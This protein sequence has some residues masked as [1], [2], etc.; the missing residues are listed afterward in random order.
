MYTFDGDTAM[1]ATNLTFTGTTDTN[2]MG[3]STVLIA[4]ATNISGVHITQP[5][6]GIGTVTVADYADTKGILFDAT[7]T[8]S[9]VVEDSAVKYKVNTVKMS[10]VDLKNWDGTVASPT[11][12]VPTGWTAQ[13]GGV[14]V[15]TDNMTKLPTN[16]APG[17]SVDILTGSAGFFADDKIQGA[18]K[19]Q[20]GDAF[21]VKPN[22]DTGM[23]ITGNAVGGIKTESEGA[24]LTYYAEK[25]SVSTITLG[26][27]TFANGGTL[28]GGA[29]TEFTN[30]YDA[31]GATITTDGLAFTNSSVMEAGDSMTILD[32]SKAIKDGSGHALPAFTTQKTSFVVG[33]TD[34][35]TDKGLTFK[36]T[37]TDTLSND[38]TTTKHIIWFYS[39]LILYPSIFIVNA[40]ITPSNVTA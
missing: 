34:E 22:S 39:I 36:G 31:T 4:N 14:A 32:A 9:V 19:Y 30:E 26:T 20:N 13:D 24:K 37:H 29:A 38:Q 3:Q 10:S 7:A 15:Y 11:S 28:Y 21:T 23:V 2:P 18:R 17:G 5:G 8:G 35:V 12:A 1:N 40:I 33:F 27:A 16:L 25:K 6:T